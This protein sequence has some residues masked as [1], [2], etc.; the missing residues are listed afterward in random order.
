MGRPPWWRRKL[1][2]RRSTVALL[3][4]GAAAGITVGLTTSGIVRTLGV[5]LSGACLIV[6]IQLAL[7]LRRR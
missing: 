1:P 6:C 7:I 3:A 4:A 2:A 5:A